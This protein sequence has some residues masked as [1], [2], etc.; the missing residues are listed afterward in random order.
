MLDSTPE[1]VLA[2]ARS[3]VSE[4]V[5]VLARE[6]AEKKTAPTAPPPQNCAGCE[7]ERTG[8]YP[9]HNGSRYC[10]SGAIAAGGALAHCSCDV[11]F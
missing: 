3:I 2:S 8:M 4:S 11:C 10:E 6:Y 7:R 9:R 1:S 5:G